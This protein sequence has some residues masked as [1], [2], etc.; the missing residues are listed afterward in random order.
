[1]PGHLDVIEIPCTNPITVAL[2]GNN[3]IVIA[4]L[5][6]DGRRASVYF[7]VQQQ[8]QSP[9]RSSHLRSTSRNEVHNAQHYHRTSA[10]QLPA[11]SCKRATARRHPTD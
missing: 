3:D 5:H 6:D 8:T 10:F 7:D 1:M 11:R 4:Q 2:G 9:R